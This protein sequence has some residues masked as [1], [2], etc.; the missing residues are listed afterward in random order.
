MSW[1][2]FRI[3]ISYRKHQHHRASTNRGCRLWKRET[4]K[5]ESTEVRNATKKRHQTEEGD[6]IEGENW[7]HGRSQE[8]SRSRKSMVNLHEV[9]QPCAFFLILLSSHEWHV[10]DHIIMAN[11]VLDTVTNNDI[12][13]LRH[14][15][16]ILQRDK[17]QTALHKFLKWRYDS[18][19][20]WHFGNKLRVWRGSKY[21][22][23][24]GR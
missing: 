5:D 19:Y 16:E 14:C 17:T 3:A 10:L 2:G 7:D 9:N 23:C 15:V 20:L 11:D 13:L 24:K 18:C 4:W 6:W 1:K 8:H 21:G 12:Y 22:S